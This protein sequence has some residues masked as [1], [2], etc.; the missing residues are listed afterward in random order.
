[1]DKTAIDDSDD[2]GVSRAGGK[3]RRYEN[4]P[5]KLAV[6][7]IISVLFIAF[8]EYFYYLDYHGPYLETA[9]ARLLVAGPFMLSINAFATVVL[10]AVAISQIALACSFW[11]GIISAN[12][13]G[14]ERFTPSS[15]GRICFDLAKWSTVVVV[16]I[17][18]A[19]FLEQTYELVLMRL[20]GL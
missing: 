13:W 12:S 2:F 4:A 6:V 19:F 16:L 11:L 20:Y 17:I 14:W 8:T 7:A 1:M 18:D 5:R 3:R 10:S 15:P 9:H